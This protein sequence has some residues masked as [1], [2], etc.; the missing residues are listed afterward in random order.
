MRSKSRP[1][2]KL[3]RRRSPSVDS[4]AEADEW[5]DPA[6]VFL[7]TNRQFEVPLSELGRGATHEGC[8]STI[9]TP[10]E[11]TQI[12]LPRSPSPRRFPAS[13]SRVRTKVQRTGDH[14]DDAISQVSGVSRG[15]PARNQSPESDI[16]DI[17]DEASTPPVMSNPGLLDHIDTQAEDYQ[18]TQPLAEEDLETNTTQVVD[19]SDSHARQPSPTAWSSTTSRPSTN[20]RN[21]LGMV[22]PMK[23]W[24][25]QRGQQLQQAALHSVPD[26]QTQ[27]SADFSASSHATT[28]G[29]RLFEEL[30]AHLRAEQQ[31]TPQDGL[32]RQNHPHLPVVDEGSHE[33]VVVPD[34]EPSE[35]ANVS[36][37]PAQPDASSPPKA[38]LHDRPVDSSLSRPASAAE[39][40]DVS[41][42]A[43]TKDGMID[44]DDDDDDED[45]IPLSLVV[46]RPATSFA[47]PSM[48][49]SDP[50]K[51]MY[52]S[53]SHLLPPDRTL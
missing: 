36:S 22:N 4:F 8:P 20:T 27:P 41:K 33:T 40:N 44:D 29:R 17:P 42:H 45:D 35:P 52:P 47:P 50:R 2:S 30:A 53:H 21:I 3:K 14:S 32:D 6:K 25:H 43:K 39:Q 38:S 26:E 11:P 9:G 28:A 48:K 10:P 49:A 23:K 19:A 7:A 34:S 15:A 46:G 31:S 18:A 37:T 5:E 1:A 24:R 13:G 51:V 16:S 12:D